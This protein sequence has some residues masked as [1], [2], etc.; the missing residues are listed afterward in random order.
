M[1]LILV[2]FSISVIGPHI[3]PE[4]LQILRGAHLS[5][6]GEEPGEI[7]EAIEAQVPAYLGNAQ[8]RILNHFLCLFEPYRVDILHTGHAQLIGNR[9]VD[10]INPCLS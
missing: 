6:L 3:V 8:F 10:V 2:L 4:G 1:T 7:L 5:P 9:P